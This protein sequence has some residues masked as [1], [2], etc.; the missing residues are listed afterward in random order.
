MPPAGAGVVLL[1]V[2]PWGVWGRLRGLSTMT[3]R[4]VVG[5]RV[6]DDQ[7]MAAWSS[8]RDW[9]VQALCRAVTFGRASVSLYPGNLGTAQLHHRKIHP[10]ATPGRLDLFTSDDVIR[11]LG[12]FAERS[13]SSS[14][15]GVAR[16]ILIASFT[17]SL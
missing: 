12:T 16:P 15:Y 9:A 1:I 6:L 17:P 11:K 3:H 7:V 5:P 10:D 2:Q 4:L 8:L 13:L 14:L